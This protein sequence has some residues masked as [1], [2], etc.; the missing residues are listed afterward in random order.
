[1][2]AIVLVAGIGIVLAVVSQPRRF[3]YERDV[4]TMSARRQETTKEVQEFTP[5]AKIEG[6]EVSIDLHGD[7]PIEMDYIETKNLTWTIA[8]GTSAPLQITDVIG[9]CS[10]VNISPKSVLVPVAS[11]VHGKITYEHGEVGIAC[12]RLSLV[13]NL[14]IVPLE[15]RSV[16]L[17][18]LEIFPR[19]VSVESD[20]RFSITLQAQYLNRPNVPQFHVTSVEFDESLLRLVSDPKVLG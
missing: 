12:R 1:M 14:G 17:R 3:A 20:N 19:S 10:C 11:S 4:R 13:T 16:K 8:N 5:S 6:V 15:F 2:A 7:G 18:H 9:D